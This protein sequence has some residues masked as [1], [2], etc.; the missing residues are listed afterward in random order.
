MLCLFHVLVAVGAFVCLCAFDLAWSVLSNCP[1]LVWSGLFWCC[2]LLVRVWCGFVVF[3][4]VCSL[5]LVW[6]VL[7]VCFDLTCSKIC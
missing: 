1:Y 5:V 7:S 6:F 2:V 3:C 4:F